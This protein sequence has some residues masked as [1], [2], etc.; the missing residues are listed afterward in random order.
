MYDEKFIEQCMPQLVELAKKYANHSHDCEDL[1][2]EGQLYLLE[3]L[4]NKQ[5]YNC[6]TTE[7]YQS[8]DEKLN[9]IVNG[10]PKTIDYYEQLYKISNERLYDLIKKNLSPT[11]HKIIIEYYGFCG[12]CKSTD[13]L[14]KEY[15]VPK[16]DIIDIK[17][18]AED[19]IK[20]CFI[21]CGINIM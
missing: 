3:Y 9:Y 4:K 21:K 12:K 1:L 6:D 16:C 18:N 8:L 19:K 20:K 14:S 13:E 5:E 2:S 7:F 10:Y 15:K 11:E 17:C